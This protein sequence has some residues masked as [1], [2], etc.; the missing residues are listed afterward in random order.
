MT[1]NYKDGFHLTRTEWLAVLSFAHRFEM[2]GIFDQAV[3]NLFDPASRGEALEF[4][5]AADKYGV[6][7]I[8]L[9]PSLRIILKDNQ[10][11]DEGEIMQMSI[12]ILARVWRAREMWIRES[13][14]Q[15]NYHGNIDNII[16]TVWSIPGYVV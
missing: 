4:L 9:I 11:P 6:E 16:R 10:T 1:R 5:I 12:G 14:G 8:H 7:V 3:K 13:R 2:K 15:W